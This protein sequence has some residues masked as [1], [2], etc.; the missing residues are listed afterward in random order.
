VCA[1]ARALAHTF[2]LFKQLIAFQE[3]WNEHYAT[4]G[5]SKA[6]PS[7]VLT[8]NNNMAHAQSYAS[9][10]DMTAIYLRDTYSNRS[11]KKNATFVNQM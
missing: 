4:N 2:Q 8:S 7:Q 6:T 10:S 1:R 9:T 5:C 11:W 3:T